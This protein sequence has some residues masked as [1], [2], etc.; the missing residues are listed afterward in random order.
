MSLTLSLDYPYTTAVE[1]AWAAL[2][3]SNK[4]A[5]WIMEGF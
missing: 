5:K 1:K 3:D 4:L 2:T